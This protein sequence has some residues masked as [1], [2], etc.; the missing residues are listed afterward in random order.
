MLKR[1]LLPMPK[2]AWTAA[3]IGAMLPWLVA[4]KPDPVASFLSGTEMPIWLLTL[5]SL[6]SP[7]LTYGILRMGSAARHAVAGFLLGKARAMKEDL[8]PSNDPIASGL[9]NAARDLMRDDERK[10]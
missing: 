2:G 7:P 5:L 8:D 10:R 6:V 9:E 1:I 3:S 4:A